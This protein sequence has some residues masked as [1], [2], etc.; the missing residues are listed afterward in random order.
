M[1]KTKGAGNK[2]KVKG[3][4][5]GPA[6][7][8]VYSTSSPTMPTDGLINWVKADAGVAFD[9]VHTTE[10]MTWSDQSGNGTNWQIKSAIDPIARP[11]IYVVN[12]AQNGLPALQSY[13]NLAGSLQWSRT[14]SPQSSYM[15]QPAFISGSTAAEVFVVLKSNKSAGDVNYAWGGFGSES[16]LLNH[17]PYGYNIYES[18]G[19]PNGQR[20]PGYSVSGSSV[21]NF[22]IYNVS[23][24]SGSNNHVVR[25]NGSVIGTWTASSVSWN[26]T[27][28]L[29]SG[30]FD[31]AGYQ[32]EGEIGEMLIYS[33]VLS[34][35]ERSIVHNYLKGRWNTP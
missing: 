11:K 3:N 1:I 24:A 6:F 14:G 28:Y 23:V 34:S 31:Q 29:F 2:I 12:N 25:L 15:T 8:V 16:Y 27:F 30:I 17:Y 5:P 35:A 4:G 10:V 21:T 26:S 18:F 9:P 19:L 22:G 33:R 13:K 7:K 32:W 20:T